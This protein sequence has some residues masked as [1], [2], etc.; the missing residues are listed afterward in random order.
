MRKD[1]GFEV[2]D[3]ID[4]TYEAD[5]KVSAIFSKYGENIK[6][7]VLAVSISEGNLSGFEKDWNI[8]GESVKLAVKKQ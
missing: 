6:S 2:M 8:N 4:V 3:H 5:E 1:A 7:E